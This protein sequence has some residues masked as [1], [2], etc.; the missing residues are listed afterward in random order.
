MCG[1]VEEY[2]DQL[3]E[4]KLCLDVEEWET[5]KFNSSYS[6]LRP[7]II[8]VPKT[9]EIHVC[10]VNTDSGTPFISA[11]EVRPVDDSMY[12]KTQFGSLALFGS[13]N[14]EIVIR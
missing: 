7:E 9:D 13:E 2:N 1:N 5:V 6:I 4:F 8:H 10:L 11:L 14:Y 3:P 12:N